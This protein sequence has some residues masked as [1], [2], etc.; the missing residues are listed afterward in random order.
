MIKAKPRKLN[1]VERLQYAWFKMTL[2]MI[3][4]KVVGAM[5]EHGNTGWKVVNQ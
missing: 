2:A 1:H 5:D 4:M 3:G